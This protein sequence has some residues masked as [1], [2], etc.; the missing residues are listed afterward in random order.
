MKIAWSFGVTKL[1]AW[2]TPA[3]V[4]RL[5]AILGKVCH[6]GRAKIQVPK[7]SSRYLSAWKS[8]LVYN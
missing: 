2:D 6:F 7:S 1:L 8:V 4:Q 5:S 3:L